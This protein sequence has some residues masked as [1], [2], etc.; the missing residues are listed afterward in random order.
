MFFRILTRI[1]VD[2]KFFI[3][4]LEIVNDC[5]FRQIRHVCHVFQEL[6]FWRILLLN[7]LRL[8]QFDLVV[9]SLDLDLAVL[10]TELLALDVAEFLVRNPAGGF[11]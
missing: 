2:E 6:V 10:F 3:S 9:D 7:L 11:G 4:T 5:S 1:S 8:V